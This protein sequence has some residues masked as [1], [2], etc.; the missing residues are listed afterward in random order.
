MKLTPRNFFT[1]SGLLLP[2]LISLSA[3]MMPVTAY[4]QAAPE[5]W[6]DQRAELVA[7]EAAQAVI[8]ERTQTLAQQRSQQAQK[9]SQQT[10]IAAKSAAVTMAAAQTTV[11]SANLVS[12]AT[13][14]TQLAAALD[15]DPRRIYQFVRNHFT[16]APYYGALK[17]P[18]LTLKERS[19]ND[20]DQAAVLV[21]LLRAAG[22]SANYQYGNMSIPL[23][24]ANHNDM[25]HWLGTDGDATRI[26]TIIASG[27]IPVAALSVTSVTLDRIWVVANINGTNVALDP[28]F[29]PST[30]QAAINLTTAMGYDKA[31]LLTSAGG[32]LGT[33]SIQNLN[34]GNLNGHLN[35]LTTQLLSH[36]KQNYPNAA[37]SD[38]V[39]GL[40]IIPDASAS[41]PVVLPF[42][43]TATQP[44][45]TAI[46]SGYIHTVR[47]QHGGIDTTLNI[48]Q[49]AGKKLSISYVGDNTVIAPPPAGV[50]DFGT[51]SPGAET[52]PYTWSPSNPNPG[53]IQV[54]STITGADA[55][56]FAFVSGGG[57]QNIPAK[58]G[59][60]NGSVQVKVKFTGINQTAG[61]KNATLTLTF[62]NPNTG[63]IIGSP[64]VTALTGAVVSIPA[65]QLYL[66]DALLQSEGTPSGN[67]TSLV[68][69]VDHPYSAVVD[70]PCF[71]G[72][73]FADQCA[74]FT[75]KRSGS[76]VL[77]SAFGGDRNSSLLTERQRYLDQLTQQGAANTSREVL[78]ET[79]N[80]FGQSWMQQTQLAADLLGTL[81]DHRLINHHRFGIVGQEEGYFIDVK[82]QFTPTLPQSATAVAGA[83]QASGLIHSAMEHSVLE[84]LQG[85]NQAAL[86]T[87]KLFALNNQSGNKFFL[88]NATNFGSI[89]SQ[90][91]G[92]STDDISDMQARINYGAQ[93][94]LSQN[95]QVALNSWHGKGF[96][97]Y[98]VTSNNL[99][100]GM[101]IGGNLNGGYGSNIGPV[102]TPMAQV[103]YAPLQIWQAN[104]ST[105]KGLDPVD[106]GSGAY[107]NQAVDLSLGGSGARGLSFARSYNSQQANQDPAGLGNG[108][109]HS[110]NI[111]LIQHSD[112][113]TALGLRSPQDAAALIV[114]TTI[115]RDLMAASQPSVQEWTV[116]A[117]IAQWATEQ[118]LDNAVSIQLG[119]RALSYRHNPDGSFVPPPGVTTQLIKNAGGTY[120]LKERFG[121]VLAFNANNH[122]QSLTDIDGNVLSFT[123]AGNV[124]TQIKDAYNRTLSLSYTGGKLTQVVD[125]QGRSVSYSYTGTDL[126]GFHDP[127]NKAWQY[128]YDTG[129]QILTVTD[130]VGSVIVNNVYDDH[131]RVTQQTAPR[132][133]GS[134]L[135]KLHY[136]GFSSSEE[137]PMGHRTTYYYDDS[138]RTIAVENA[139]GYQSKV[140]YD[141]QGHVIQS[142]DPLGNTSQTSYDANHNPIQSLNAQNQPTSFSYDAQ[143]RLTQV[144]DALTHTAQIDYDAKHHPIA[145]RNALNQQTASAYSAAGLVQ[146]R[147]DA[148]NTTTQTTYDT[149]GHPATVKT[150]AHPQVATQVDAIGR[151]QSLTDQGGAIT[152]FSYDKRGLLLTRTDPL[153][154]L[155]ST[156]YD[157]TGRP[158]S[159][160]DRNGA[161]VTS[162]YTPSGKLSQIGYPGNQTV[163]FTYNTLDQLTGMTDPTGTTA[164]SYDAAGRLTGSTDPQGFQV[165]YQYDAAGN[166]TTLTYPGNLTVSYGYDNLNRLTT[167]NIGW[168]N[169][170]ESVSYDAAGR[171]TQAGRF[172]GSQTSYQYDN[173]DRLT[174]LSHSAASQTLASY[175]YTLDANGNR[176][177][178]IATE[179]KLP[180]KLINASQTYTYNTQKNRLTSQNSTALTYD[181]EGQLKTQGSTNYSYDY[182]HRLIS[183]GTSSYVYDGIGNRIKATRNGVITKYIYDAT[184][185]LLAEA[186]SSNVITRYYIYAKGLTALVDAAT[187]Q[188]YVYHFDGT[189]HTVALT[190]TSQQTVNTYAYDPYGKLMAETETIA[191]PFKYAGQVGIQAEGNNLYYMRARYY[192][193]NL[194]RFISEDPAGFVDGTNLYAY[195]GGNPVMGVDP[196][197]TDTLYLGVNVNIQTPVDIANAIFGTNIIG[198]GGGLGLAVSAPGP[199]GGEFDIGGYITGTANSNNGENGYDIGGKKYG[200]SGDVELGYG[201]G[202]VSDLAGN[203]GQIGFND[204]VG[205]M[206]LSFDKN[207]GL[208]G[209]G[210]HLGPG[211]S[212]GGSGTL[213]T[214]FSA[215]RGMK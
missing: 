174:G 6:L 77:A 3:L 147:T 93:L 12:A 95:G 152:Q 69:T 165:S 114:A 146:S 25:A 81:S 192:D 14:F 88:A 126:T 177:K 178:A 163:N 24:A 19:G 11:T 48:P 149:N 85:A 27:G 32:M 166:L 78:S 100:L 82:A 18:L 208:Q 22:F 155:N 194:G 214:T 120:Q 66:D 148:K 38:V 181:F 45:W 209:G 161:V 207:G 89:Q 109:N 1:T 42:T 92:Y 58:V 144:T 118:L 121:T 119:D 16:Y 8:V 65:A 199:N 75:L 136:T 201:K 138:G 153:G 110:Y 41:L 131:N 91:T 28:A 36:L 79:L 168:L 40:T 122:I 130:P 184:G 26:G 183:Q 72:A 190:N 188:L 52:L 162:S 186:N 191:Q 133:T 62:K 123:Y 137:D 127:E 17:G 43:G 54:T 64:Q 73:K 94:I 35:T 67:L 57:T 169:K 68:L 212:I 55:S 141:G 60:V 5:G 97:D 151:L 103:Q 76:Y 179:P 51:V 49:I 196:L 7:P 193:A 198:N 105:P 135:Y 142:T 56:A 170:T 21:E 132:Q 158:I 143:Q 182:A 211:L 159:H 106:L 98:R 102:N 31:A 86:S 164:N 99:S 189:G 150:G 140:E 171:H 117:L 129:H 29:K 70:T 37:V 154:K 157:N 180:E 13:E 83:F 202:S 59:S 203:G 4:T 10:A 87:I 33:N 175:Q 9:Q 205:G 61:R 139:L 80:V 176:T 15:N 113:K 107:L 115:T 96:I 34:A 187:G 210:V 2:L 112:F 213:T 47:L 195:V 125:N 23:T 30:K 20:F 206:T 145:A 173:A 46:P 200:F 172:N 167:V 197:G 128:G 104:I 215:R 39:G 108:W 156:A 204:G 124:L 71:I 74:T 101:I 185:N 63:L 90:L 134:A 111:G 53:V 160:T 84:Q 44:L 50:T 116:G